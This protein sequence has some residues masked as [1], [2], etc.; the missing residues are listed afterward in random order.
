[1][2]SIE[3]RIKDLEDRLSRT[4]VNKA[5]MRSVCYIKSQLAK[6]RTDLVVAASSKKGGGT[7]FGIKKSGDAQVAFIGFP[8]VGKSSLLNIL[9]KGA[10]SS[11]VAAYDFTTVNAI[12]GMMTIEGAN[13]QLIDLPGI[14]LGAAEGKGKGRE[15]LGVVRTCDLILIL[16]CFQPDGRLDI[17]DRYRIRD[18][19]YNVG[20]RLN[21]AP[22]KL[23]IRP[24]IR[25]G[26]I[27]NAVV[28]QTQ[29]LDEDTIQMIL[30]EHRVINASVSLREDLSIDE[31]IDGIQGN[32]RYIK[33]LV[34]IT[35]SDL[36][37]PQDLAQVPRLLKNTEYLCISPLQGTNIEALRLKIF[38]LL[39]LI[40]IFLKQ[41]GKPADMD[42][43]LILKRGSTL[44]VL[45]GSIHREFIK[46][47]R[48]AL[49]W[50]PSAKHSG[51]RFLRLDHVLKDQ[52]VV[53]IVTR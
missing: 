39:D 46:K 8:S 51:Q 20:I 38:E 3:D 25:G 11:K 29:G 37:S 32:R 16:I 18:E 26:I 4:V 13:I 44:K 23:T 14:I 31:F 7:G 2:P 21:T 10:T 36:A 35:K 48:Y 34:V 33:E 41:P 52:D 5:T 22:P 42:V 1:M 19:L 15:I 6:L 53:Q 17:K 45:C 49:I 24:Q 40:R 27:I 43:P 50:G 9:T 47:F 30:A 28:R 12:P